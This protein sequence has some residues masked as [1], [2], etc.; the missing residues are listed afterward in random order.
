[1]EELLEKA[2][3]NCY[4]SDPNNAE[5][6]LKAI[7]DKG[8]ESVLEHCCI[9]VM[10]ECSRTC[11]HQL[12]RHRLGA[13]SQASQRYINYTKK[14]VAFIAPPKLSIGHYGSNNRAWSEHPFFKAVFQSLW[15]Y[16][17]LLKEGWKPEEARDVLLECVATQV[18]TTFNVRQWR[19]VFRER[20]LNSHAQKP[21]RELF[22]GILREF[23][24]KTY[25]FDDLGE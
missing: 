18:V 7:I 9:T 19:H 1:M 2:G 13:Y 8:H 3:R 20:A 25:L 12:V 15:S 17:A 21:I 5:V 23:K 11:S 24:T 10:I 4:R 6:F 16:E 14:P 22:L